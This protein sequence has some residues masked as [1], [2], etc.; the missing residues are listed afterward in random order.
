MNE[1]YEFAK[2]KG[3]AWAA[4]CNCYNR[5]RSNSGRCQN[6]DITDPTK[7]FG[8]MG[9]ICEECRMHCDKERQFK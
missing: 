6:R 2:E 9:A 5:H 7:E 1:Q 3:I 8:K 4:R